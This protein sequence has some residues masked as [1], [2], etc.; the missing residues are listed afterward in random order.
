VQVVF[1]ILPFEKTQIF[2][3]NL[4]F[5]VDSEFETI[6][7][8]IDD[9][10]IR[11]GAISAQKDEIVLIPMNMRDGCIIARGKGNTDWNCSAPHG[12]GRIMSRGEAKKQ[13][14]IDDYRN[15]M[16]GIYTSCVDSRT[17]DE[18]PAAYKPFETILNDIHDTVDIVDIIK[19]R[20]N[21][22]GV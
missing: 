18:A 12:A 21:Y 4:G 6:H 1:A 22:K 13:I 7:N 10:F 3:G 19:S 15:S 2:I 5:E 20:Y 17:L 14:A 9:H 16:S 8:Y 11:K